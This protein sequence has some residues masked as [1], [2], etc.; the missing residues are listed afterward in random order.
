MIFSTKIS[1]VL[2]RFK[3]LLKIS[4]K[5]SKSMSDKKINSND[6]VNRLF[7]NKNW[8]FNKKMSFFCRKR[9]KRKVIIFVINFLFDVINCDCFDDNSNEKFSFLTIDKKFKYFYVCQYCEM[10]RWNFW[11]IDLKMKRFK[12]QFEKKKTTLRN[13]RYE[14]H[15]VNH[16]HLSIE[17]WLLLWRWQYK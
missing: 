2:S 5:S 14:C 1:R 6:N 9:K 3:M 13:Q 4:T 15:V 17:N 12:I 16:E 10:L 7:L 8:F 11:I